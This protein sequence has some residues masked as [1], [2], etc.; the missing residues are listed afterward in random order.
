MKYPSET[1]RA[2]AAQAASASEAD[3]LLRLGEALAGE[4]ARDSDQQNLRSRGEDW[5]RRNRMRFKELVCGNP[6]F[7]DLGDSMVDV[8]T[9]ADALCVLLNRPTAFIV[10]AI[11]IKRGISTLCS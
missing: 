7:A 8:A 11:L 1:D 9:L 6:V 3:L 4:P 10:A 5:L 2:L